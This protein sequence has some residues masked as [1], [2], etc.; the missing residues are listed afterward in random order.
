MTTAT[1]SSILQDGALRAQDIASE[2]F[3]TG[4]TATADMLDGAAERIKSGG[5][6]VDHAARATADRIA[7]SAQYVRKNDATAMST[8]LM[9]AVRKNPGRYM[10]GAVVLGFL[11]GRMMMRRPEKE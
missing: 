7:D 8:D 2:A 1:R 4:R 10:I 6:H 3:K 11:A 5:E 9:V